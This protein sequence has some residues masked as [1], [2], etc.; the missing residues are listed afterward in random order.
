MKKVIVT[1]NGIK[2]IELT[3]EEIA[4]LEEQNVLQELEYL[5]KPSTQEI[6]QAEFELK[7]IETLLMLGVI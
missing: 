4:Q 3:P 7:V 6:E 5:L 1:E 2:E